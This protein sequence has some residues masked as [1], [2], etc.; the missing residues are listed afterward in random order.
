MS[1]VMHGSMSQ[2][3]TVAPV[4][5][6]TPKFSKLLVTLSDEVKEVSLLF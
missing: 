4:E 1:V 2:L 6:R 5:G 3:S